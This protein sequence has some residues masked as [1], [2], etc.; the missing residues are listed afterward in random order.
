MTF[1]HI[2]ESAPGASSSSLDSNGKEGGP[3]DEESVDDEQF[4]QSLAAFGLK[5]RKERKSQ[6]SERKRAKSAKA[7]RKRK[8]R[9]RCSFPREYEEVTRAGRQNFWGATVYGK[10]SSAAAPAH[11]SIYEQFHAG[12]A[13]IKGQVVIQNN[14][15]SVM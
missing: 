14:D 12:N 2:E 4:E 6:R 8:R 1:S 5:R 13:I 7:P 3:E 15:F 9:R 10:K 11:E